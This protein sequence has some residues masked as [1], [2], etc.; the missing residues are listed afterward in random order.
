MRQLNEDNVTDAVIA[1]FAN[2]PNPRLKEVMTSLI[3]HLHDFVREVEPT[4]A[5]WL[6]AI[7]FLLDTAAKSDDKRN[8]FILLSDTVGITML[9]DFINHR[10]AAGATETSVLGPFYAEGAP[11][12]PNGADMRG[13]RTN[14]DQGESVVVRGSVRD[15]DGNPIANALLDIWETGPDGFYHMQKPGEKPVFEFAG[16]IRTDANGG[17]QFCTYKPVSYSVPT[18]GPVGDILNGLGRHAFRP[19]H[20]HMIISAE[21]F[22]S[23]ITQLFTDGDEYIESDAVFGVKD[24][25]VVAYKSGSESALEEQYGFEKPWWTVDYDFVLESSAN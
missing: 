5:E 2:A 19:A 13:D 9:V 17:Y 14:G 16:K 24:S 20:L 22:D 1:T 25:L 10:K 8:E 7:Q 6:Q 3:R 23:I 15:M 11:E 4:E 12:Y 18:D 21:G